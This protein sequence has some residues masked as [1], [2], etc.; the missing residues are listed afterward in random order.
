MRS[1]SVLGLALLSTMRFKACDYAH[2]I[3]RMAMLTE[4]PSKACIESAI[5]SVDGIEDVRYQE[6]QGSLPLTLT[7][8]KPR[9]NVYHFI[10]SVNGIGAAM[11][12]ITNYKGEIQYSQNHMA[13]NSTPPQ[14]DVDR[15]RSIMVQIEHALETR[16][17]VRSLSE[18]IE[19]ICPGVSCPK[20]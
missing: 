14:Q 9:D 5:R 13:M 18:S 8:I 20:G 3:R 16:C 10:Y 7:G 2:G 1:L 12:I 17:G 11:S 19:E 6:S 4:F 15:I